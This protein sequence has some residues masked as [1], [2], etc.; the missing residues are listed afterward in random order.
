M[1]GKMSLGKRDNGSEIMLRKRKFAEHERQ[2]QR[3]TGG[4]V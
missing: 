2:C 3:L 4:L 1:I